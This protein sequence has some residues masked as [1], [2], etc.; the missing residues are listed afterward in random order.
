M[1]MPEYLCCSAHSLNIL[2]PH[3]IV[4]VTSGATIMCHT[5]RVLQFIQVI[6]ENYSIMAV[7]SPHPTLLTPFS[8]WQFLLS[9]LVLINTFTSWPHMNFPFCLVDYS[10]QQKAYCIRCTCLS[11]LCLPDIPW[12]FSINY[13]FSTTPVPSQSSSTWID[14]YC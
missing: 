9:L 11:S 2:S 14:F 13:S 5:A 1:Y 10:M 12:L 8:L 4:F 3:M 6:E 7:I